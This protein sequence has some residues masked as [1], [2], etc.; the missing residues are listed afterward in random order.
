MVNN[1]S[2]TEAAVA[3]IIAIAIWCSKEAWQSYNERVTRSEE[4]TSRLASDTEREETMRTAIKA[5]ENS[6][7]AITNKEGSPVPVLLKPA[8]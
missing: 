1:M 6:N 3:A 2:G 8:K 4:I 5:L 7:N